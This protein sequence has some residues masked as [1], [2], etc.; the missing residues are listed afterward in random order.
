MTY[1]LRPTIIK[2]KKRARDLLDYGLLVIKIGA[3]FV[4]CVF[5]E[6]FVFAEYY[7]KAPG[8]M[9]ELVEL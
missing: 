2:H 6:K 3:S 9:I 7:Y 4:L 1:F 8:S 5:K